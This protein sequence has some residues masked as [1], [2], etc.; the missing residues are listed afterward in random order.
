MPPITEEMEHMGDEYAKNCKKC[1]QALGLQ[2]PHPHGQSESMHVV[3][4]DLSGPHVE[5]NGTKFKYFMV[6]IYKA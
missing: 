2:R 5:S 4:A 1:R 3:S 6:A